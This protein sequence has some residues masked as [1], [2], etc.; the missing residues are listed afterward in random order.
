MRTRTKSSI[1]RTTFTALFAALIC[2]GCVI[3]IKLPGGVPITVQNLFAMLAALILGGLQGS[4]AVGLFLIL[5]VVG[6]PVFSGAV[7]GWAVFVGPTGG[8]LWGY[9]LGAAVAGLIAG[10]PHVEEKKFRL[11]NWIRIAIASLVGFALIYLPGIPWF[12]HIMAGKGNPVTFNK[13]LEY[14]LI[15]FIPGDVLKMLVSVPLAALLRPVA[16]RYLYPDDE[17]EMAE[18]IDEL[19]KRKQIMDKITGKNK[20][21][22]SDK[23]ASTENKS[24][25]E[26]SK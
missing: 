20:K 24:E 25:S 14:T 10:T 2:L 12:I 3:S 23:D 17:A 13:A 1:V 8:F 7:G 11:K 5:G 9:F 21:G 6:L 16:A 18:I 22:K 4:G 26:K 19:K 15:P